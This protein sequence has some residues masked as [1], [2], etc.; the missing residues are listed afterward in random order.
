MTTLVIV[1]SPAKAK[2]LGRFLGRGYVVRAS[3]GHVRDLPP[4]ELGVD[5]E[6]GFKPT[7]HQLAKKRKT[8]AQ[9]RAALD[10]A[11]RVVLATDPDREGEAI[12]WHLVQVLKPGIPVQRVTFHEITESAV[13]AAF[14]AP[15]A[16]DMSLVDAQQARRVLDRLVGYQISPLL[17]RTIGGKSAGRVQSVAVR[18]VVDREREIR[19]FMPEEYWTLHADLA[20]VADH[21]QHFLAKLM[22][23]GGKKA[24]LKSKADA[25][26]VIAALQGAAYTVDKIKREKKERRP[27]PPFTTSTLQQGAS[28]RLHMA[29]SETMK[30]AQQ[31]YEGVDIGAGKA[32]GLITYMRTDSTAVSPEAQQA[33]RTFIAE[34]YGA[35]YLPD[36]PPHYASRVKNAQEAHEAIRPTDVRRT[37]E[38]LKPLLD[39][40]AWQLYD[41]IWRRFVASQMK[42]AVYDVTTVDVSAPG[43]GKTHL[44][45]AIGRALLFDGFLRVLE[46]PEEQSDDDDAPQRLPPLAEG[47]RLDL[48]AL[49]PKQ[50]FTK[51]PPRYTEAALVKALEERG[52]GRPSTYASIMATIKDRGYVAVEERRLGPTPLGEAVC[53]ALIATFPSVMDYAFTAQLEDQLDDVSRGERGWTA[54]LGEWYGPFEQALAGAKDILKTMPRAPKPEVSGERPA[55]GRRGR[56]SERTPAEPTGET[57]PEC[58]KPLVKRAGKFGEFV[59]CS[60]YPACRY[61]V[62]DTGAG[63][64]AAEGRAPRAG[65]KQAPTRR[66]RKRKTAPN[67]AEDVTEDNMLGNCPKCGKPLVQKSGKFGPFVGCSGYPECRYIQRKGR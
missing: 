12:A 45:R 27:W 46:E 31:L 56:K 47:E 15:R 19:N 39:R 20:K 30:H 62:R 41:L 10:G 25:D 21:A 43:G 26:A 61:I 66:A 63:A 34:N 22:L 65:T 55:K 1:E 9:L 29:P 33:A 44:F 58:G 14:A 64:A 38:S 2:T 60:G 49:I 59:G 4:K 42:P 37:P 28:A 13:R 53:D 52:I 5:V 16:L 7:Y 17:W 8:I 6:H 36:R 50:H 23:I 32:V 11:E 3:L 51:P 57:C 35:D 54:V 18:L 48:L 24:E 40:R 67:G